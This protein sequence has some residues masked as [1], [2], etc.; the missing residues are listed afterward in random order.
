[1]SPPRLLLALA[2]ALAFA[3]ALT[4]DKGYELIRTA[5]TGPEPA[6]ESAARR[7]AESGDRGFVPALVDAL[8]FVK[9]DRR[10]P[11]LGA[12]RK[13]TGEDPGARYHDWVELVGRR[14]DL[15]PAPGYLAWKG[16]LFGRI[17]P[18]YRTLF[19]AGAAA[20]RSPR[21]PRTVDGAGSA[22]PACSIAAIN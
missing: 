21:G 9:A 15:Q 19:A 17:D 5:M 12:L 22:R 13:L 3:A 20:S 7:L 4:P 16:T 14:G 2:L 8:F 6:R 10:E 1:M 18:R 11:L